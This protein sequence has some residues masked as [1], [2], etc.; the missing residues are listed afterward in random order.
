MGPF[1]PVGP[2]LAKRG[3]KPSGSVLRHQTNSLGVKFFHLCVYPFMLF[4]TQRSFQQH[5]NHANQIP[6]EKFMSLRS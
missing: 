4:Y 6:Y 1:L 3:M 5:N 2:S